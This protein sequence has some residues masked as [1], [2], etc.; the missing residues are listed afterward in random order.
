MQIKKI[1]IIIADDHSLFIE[2]I[3]LLL[4]KERGLFIAGVA[5][6]GRELLDL[7][8]HQTTDIILLDINM[9]KI[10]GLEA[11]RIIRQSY[12]Q[13][14]IIVLSTYNEGHLIDKAKQYGANGYLLKNC[15]KEELLQ[16]IRLV[17]S[18]H[19]SF[20]YNVTKD[21]NEFNRKSK[22]AIRHQKNDLRKSF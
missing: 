14:K 1:D 6:D 18:G 10:N 2:G 11:T 8:Q 20:P 21:K 15:S 3:T 9:P 13:T 4:K 22:L 17:Y 7:L 19:T 16:T 5:N 12:A